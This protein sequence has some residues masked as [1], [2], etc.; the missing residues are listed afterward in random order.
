MTKKRIIKISIILTI[1]F[2]IIISIFDIKKAIGYL[3][4]SGLSIYSLNSIEKYATIALE[5]TSREASK[6]MR[7][8]FFK[9]YLITG[10]VLFL[11]IAISNSKIVFLLTIIGAFQI[12]L[13]ILSLCIPKVFKII[14]VEKYKKFLN[15]YNNEF[16]GKNGE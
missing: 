7:R 2:F 14:F 11:S 10:M 15:F 4:G 5:L 9:R 12:K 3:L 16:L 6:F 13:I 8:G 1:I